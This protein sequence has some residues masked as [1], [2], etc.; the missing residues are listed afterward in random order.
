MKD[1][2]SRKLIFFKALL[3]LCGGLLAAGTLLLEN[4]S[5]KTAVLLILAVWC[6]ARLYYFMFY[7]IEHYVDN[8]Y[9]YAGILSF[10]AYLRKGRKKQGASHA[11]SDRK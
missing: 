10:L 3:F 6:F 8:D 5:W 7:V 2:T 4:P 1:L 9:K 11:P